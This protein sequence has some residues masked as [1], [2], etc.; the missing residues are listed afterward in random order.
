MKVSPEE[1]VKSEE[2]EKTPVPTLIID[3]EPTVC[4]TDFNQIIQQNGDQTQIGYVET[5]HNTM[6][7]NDLNEDRVSFSDFEETLNDLVFEPMNTD[8]FEVL[9]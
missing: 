3:T 8:D 2:P 1:S 9:E 7:N 5:N 4:F 6:Y